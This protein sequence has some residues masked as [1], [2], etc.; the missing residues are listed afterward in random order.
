MRIYAP[1]RMQ[2]V[3][4]LPGQ[5]KLKFR[6]GLRQAGGAC[7]RR[8][9]ACGPPTCPRPQAKPAVAA[10]A[11]P[12]DAFAAAALPSSC[13]PWTPCPAAQPYHTAHA[14]LCFSL[15]HCRQPGQHTEEELR[16]GDLRSQLEEKERKH[17][18][19]TKSANFEGGW[20][21]GAVRVARAAVCGAQLL[22]LE[23]ACVVRA[24]P[25]AC[26]VWWQGS[27]SGSA[28]PPV[29]QRSERKT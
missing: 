2:S 19:K 26:R 21:G 7:R 9:T 16:A 20:R 10:V 1:S 12:K 28:V 6:C 14:S 17:R 11:A 15:W 29:L 22:V 3:K 25:H 5:T 13:R 8:V 23:R 27:S 24:V 18:L 4:D